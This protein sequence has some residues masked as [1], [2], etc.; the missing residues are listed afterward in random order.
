MQMASTE[1]VL[2]AK[3]CVPPDSQADA[4]H[5]QKNEQKILQYIIP[6][7][8]MK[9]LSP[10]FLLYMHFSVIAFLYVHK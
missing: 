2:T 8:D 1:W 3:L 10:H 6:V 4:L 5:E 9:G 7:C